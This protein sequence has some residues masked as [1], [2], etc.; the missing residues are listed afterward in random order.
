MNLTELRK[1]AEA[2]TPGSWQYFKD[3]Q[4]IQTV[5]QADAAY[6]AALS[7]EVVK[8]MAEAVLAA[9]RMIS[10]PFDVDDDLHMQCAE[11]LDAAIAAVAAALGAQ[12]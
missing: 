6:I 10:V 8:A 3:W 7:P 12:T 1:L 2:A 4:S 9:H 5:D 11:N